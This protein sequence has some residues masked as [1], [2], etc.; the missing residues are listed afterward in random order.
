VPS[1]PYFG[2]KPIG[3]VICLLFSDKNLEKSHEKLF[4]KLME[5]SKKIFDKGKNIGSLPKKISSTK[6]D[7]YCEDL[8]L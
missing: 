1:H 2:R 3:K 6:W 4:E 7:R 5:L 8:R